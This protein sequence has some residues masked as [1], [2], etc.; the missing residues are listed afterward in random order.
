MFEVLVLLLLGG[1]AIFA[2]FF[3]RP[4]AQRKTP[5]HPP[6]N[7]SGPRNYPPGWDSVPHDPDAGD[8]QVAL[9]C[10][11]LQQFLLQKHD[12]GR[13]G[14]VTFWWRNHRV[15]SVCTPKA[16]MATENLITRPRVI[17]A[18]CFEPIH[19]TKSVQT[20]NGRE[21]QQR[22]ELV[23]C[24][25]RGRN[26]ESFFSDFVRIAQETEKTWSP[27]KPIQ[28]MKEM[29][30]MTLKVVLSTCLGNIFQDDSEVDWLAN[31][32]HKCKLEMDGRILKAPSPDS[33]Q[34]KIFQENLKSLNDCLKKML[35][36]YSEHENTKMIPLLEAL[37]QSGMP[38]EH[39]LLDMITF[40]GG[41]HT[42]G[43]YGMWILTYLAQ[44]PE[45]Q[46]RLYRQI[47]REVKGDCGKKLKAY[48]LSSKSYLRQ[49][50]DETLRLSTIISFAARDSDQDLTVGGYHVPAQTPIMQAI[51]V[52]MK[53]EAVWDNVDSFNPER[54]APGAKHAKRGPEFRPFGVPHTRRCPANHFTYFMMSV[55]VAIFLQRF[56]F[57]PVKEEIPE[58]KYGIATSPT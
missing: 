13:R 11:S 28:L 50:L 15:V 30:R 47:E 37:T 42:L 24:T 34:E 57:L 19:G 45:V 20:L 21:W 6:T 38:E 29:F 10:G 27:G 23:H 44:H 54:F 36:I 53:N 14:V 25:V 49:F 3:L 41:F 43:Y 22:K 9:S 18:Q 33:V 7:Q 32:Y 39:I 8:L 58:K 52:A 5:T 16:F 35:K 40:L 12:G 17:Y 56:V 46:D 48:A 1:L 4:S 2:A 55:C 31:T 51:G 26:L